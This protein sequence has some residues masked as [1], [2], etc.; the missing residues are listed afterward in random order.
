[1]VINDG[2]KKGFRNSELFSVAEKK[3]WECR[4]ND[5]IVIFKLNYHMVAC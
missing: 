1:M 5:F 2:I 4:L 3:I